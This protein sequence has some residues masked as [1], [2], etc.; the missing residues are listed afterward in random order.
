MNDGVPK[1]NFW[2]GE[3]EDGGN[4]E[5]DKAEGLKVGERSPLEIMIYPY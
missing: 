3:I 2:G 1:V 5:G 4:T